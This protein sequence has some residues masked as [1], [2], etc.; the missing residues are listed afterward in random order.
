MGQ[1]Q[2]ADH[3]F[4]STSSQLIEE[5]DPLPKIMFNA[6]AYAVLEH[7]Q[8]V[9]VKVK[10]TGPTDVDVRFRCLTTF[11]LSLSLSLIHIYLSIHTLHA[12]C[13]DAMPYCVSL[14]S[15]SL[16]I[17]KRI[18][19]QHFSSFV[20][21]LAENKNKT[22]VHSFRSINVLSNHSHLMDNLQLISR[23]GVERE[24]CR[25]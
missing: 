19:Q 12:L 3:E 1:P 4:A 5:I 21:L 16:W 2:V 8:K 14:Y 10:R 15:L 22:M 13:Y 24:Q 6:T 7:E 17:P 20:I 9:E 25:R 23:S 11:A 18:F